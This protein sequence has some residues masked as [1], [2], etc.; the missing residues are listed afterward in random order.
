[1]KVD[2]KFHTNRTLNTVWSGGS[3][4]LS[5]KQVL[6]VLGKYTHHNRDKLGFLDVGIKFR[7]GQ[8][9]TK[10]DKFFSQPNL[11]PTKEE[12][13][14]FGEPIRPKNLTQDTFDVISV[15]EW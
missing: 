6:L 14:S 4:H 5:L 12:E 3:E 9:S 13:P 8:K 7:S 11:S 10:L 15:T 1:M 2:L